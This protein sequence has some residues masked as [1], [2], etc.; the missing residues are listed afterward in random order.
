M[1]TEITCFKRTSETGRK[2]GQILLVVF[3]WKNEEGGLTSPVLQPSRTA[4]K[5]LANYWMLQTICVGYF[6]IGHERVKYWVQQELMVVSEVIR[7]SS[8]RSKTSLKTKTPCVFCGEGNQVVLVE[9]DA[10]VWEELKTVWMKAVLWVAGKCRLHAILQPARKKNTVACV[11]H[12]TGKVIF[13]AELQ[14]QLPMYRQVA[15]SQYMK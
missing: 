1:R 12:C 3:L 6:L 8:F 2:L 9:K 11:L 14:R 5:A 7:A 4:M 13:K 15:I 10:F